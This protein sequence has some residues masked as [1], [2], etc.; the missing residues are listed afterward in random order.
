MNLQ[1]SIFWLILVGL[2]LMLFVLRPKKEQEASPTAVSMTNAAPSGMAQVNTTIQSAAPSAAAIPASKPMPPASDKGEQI[3]SGLSSLNDVPI[4]FYGRLED[5]FGS[6]VPGAQ[7]AAD[8]RIYN[9][10]QS[11]VEHF[12]STSD[13]NG[14]FQIQGGKG[15][16][17]GI[18]PRKEG[19]V[20]ATTA[21][22]YKYS[23]MYADHFTPD[24]GNPTVIKMWKLQGAQPLMEIN[25]RYKVHYTD[26]PMCFD[27]IAGQMTQAGGDLKITINRSP[28]IV[29]ERTL[30]DWS[31]QL[32]AIDG[33]LIETSFAEARTTFAA[34]QDGYEPSD[35]F[36]M[37]TTPPNKWFGTFDQ[38]IFLKS[39]N[40]QVYSKVTVD[41]SINQNPDDYVWIEF[42]GVANTN[43][44]VNW[45]AT[46]LQ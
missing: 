21:T 44:S 13:E 40:G 24:Q 8:V 17:L 42:H 33:G 19:Y 45:E 27:F 29:S 34:P 35:N 6:A 46:A 4:V 18:M 39:R 12:T 15:E 5:Q 11:T 28:G 3:K 16:S 41:V 23:Y 7:I 30:K 9:G 26:A 25:Q 38:T 2:L 31:V 10:I 22:Y 20:L 1:R 37:S 14:F 43:S 36:I 32:A